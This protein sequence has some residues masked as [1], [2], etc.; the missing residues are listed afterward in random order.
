MMV[1]ILQELQ[2]LPLNN[3]LK[4]EGMKNN[5]KIRPGGFTQIT[6]VPK[7]GGSG[8]VVIFY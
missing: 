3:N 5:Y 6:S 8:M 1:G 4:N 2:L 7:Q